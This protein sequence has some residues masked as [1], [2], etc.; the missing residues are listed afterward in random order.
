[1]KDE[2]ILT[3]LKTTPTN[4]RTMK[5][6]ISEKIF[7]DWV[8][9]SKERLSDIVERINQRHE[10]AI[11]ERAIEFA[12]HWDDQLR[13]PKLMSAEDSYNEK[14]ETFNDKEK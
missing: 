1:M 14:Y 3:H 12:K 7:I 11:K 2:A 8:Y 5:E 9:E 13:I 10:E 4:L 6:L